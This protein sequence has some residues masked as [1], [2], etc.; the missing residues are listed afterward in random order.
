M[1][2]HVGAE[3]ADHLEAVN[4]FVQL[5]SLGHGDRRVVPP[6]L[7]LRAIQMYD[8][9]GL[10]EGQRTPERAIRHVQ[11][12]RVERDAGGNGQHRGR[13]EPAGATD[14]APRH[15]HVEP[16]GVDRGRH[17]TERPRRSTWRRPAMQPIARGKRQRV[18]PIPHRGA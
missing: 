14:P 10:D 5:A 1:R 7:Q 16:P 15:A 12:R 8:A 6:T 17:P 3:R 4:P 13:R 18:H 2:I 9:V 11:E